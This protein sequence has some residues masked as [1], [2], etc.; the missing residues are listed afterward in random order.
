MFTLLFVILPFITSIVFTTLT[1][2]IAEN[3]DWGKLMECFFHLPLFQ[4]IKHAK[5]VKKLNSAMQ[6][7]NFSE[8][9]AKS[10]INWINKCN[11][12][13]AKKQWNWEIIETHM[14]NDDLSET[15]T[16]KLKFLFEKEDLQMTNYIASRYLKKLV[17]H[18]KKKKENE[19]GNIEASIQEF[20]IMEAFLESFPQF[21]LQTCATINTDPSFQSIMKS[22]QLIYLTLLS[23]LISVVSSVTATF[24]KMPHIS[25][26]QK[27][28]ISQY[29]KNFL[30]VGLLMLL[31]VTP[32]LVLISIYFACCRHGISIVFLAMA[33]GAYAIPYWCYVY[34][35]FKGC[36]KE[37]LKLLLVNFA[38]SVIGPCIVIIPTSPLI[39]VSFLLSMAGHLVL[40]IILQVSSLLWPH[41][42]VISLNE[43]LPFT[44]LFMIMVPII[45]TTSLFANF[46]LEEKKQLLAKKIGLGS[47]CCDEKD[48]LK[49][50]I[51][52][53][54][55]KL[56]NRLLDSVDETTLD[57]I[58]FD[59]VDANKLGFLF[60][61]ACENGW[62]NLAEKLLTH[63]DS[64]EIINSKDNEGKTGMI[65][66]CLADRIEVVS[67]LLGYQE[68]KEMLD[69]SFQASCNKGWIEVLDALMVLPNSNDIIASKD[70]NGETGFMKAIRSGQEDVV[71]KLLNHSTNSSRDH[72]EE[73]GFMNRGMLVASFHASC[74]SGWI[75][76]L[77]FLMDLPNANGIIASKDKNGENGFMKACRSGQKEVV[78]KLL[79]HSTILSRDPD[80]E[81]GFM[82]ACRAGNANVV[83]LMLN[84]TKS[85]DIIQ[86]KDNKGETGFMKA[87]SKG[88][89]KVVELMLDHKQSPEIIQSRDDKGETGFMKALFSSQNS[90]I[91]LLNDHTNSGHR[92]ILA[93]TVQPSL[94]ER[95]FCCRCCCCYSYFEDRRR[96]RCKYL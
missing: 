80:G 92:S 86:G 33:L 69:A 15:E 62:D 41:L 31:M 90:V 60:L 17:I 44:K 16:Q 48:E 19:L 47:V 12:L 63:I 10:V 20:K 39:A 18:E 22:D 40:L 51:E 72:E 38:T 91:K 5:F 46:Q 3:K 37:T 78:S 4:L 84:H 76:V 68:N 27:V 67:V 73:P 35:K 49:W 11:E 45:I 32:R 14:K 64:N 6:E 89:L 7:L 85:Q 88:N 26:E 53:N 58:G 61:E 94:L 30:L 66:A 93:M 83:A 34:T 71:F 65:K 56:I 77:D 57:T 1:I 96:R 52:R 74:N 8:D 2:S 59:Y 24:M 36:G 95:F 28:P 79:N 43:M 23:S 75:K 55:L 50:A 25:N 42:F 70:K 54:Y 29:W 9:L 13:D 81:T 87:C 82:K 21:V